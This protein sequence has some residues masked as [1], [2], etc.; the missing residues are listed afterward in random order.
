MARGRERS[1]WNRTAD[2]MALT[3][4]CHRGKG[5]RRYRRRDFHPLAPRAKRGTVADLKE[6]L[7]P[8]RQL[9]HSIVRWNDGRCTITPAEPKP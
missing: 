8:G 7:Y 1:E 2:L 4:N 9:Q 3:A 6:A 5:T